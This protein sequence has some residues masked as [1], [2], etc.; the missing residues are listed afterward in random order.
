M[1]LLQGGDAGGKVLVILVRRGQVLLLLPKPAFQS[2]NLLTKLGLINSQ[3]RRL[4]VGIFSVRLRLGFCGFQFVHPVQHNCGEDWGEKTKRPEKGGVLRGLLLSF[5]ELLSHLSEIGEKSLVGGLKGGD[6]LSLL[7]IAGLGEIKILLR[8][9]ELGLKLVKIALK[10]LGGLI[11]RR[12]GR[13]GSRTART[14]QGGG[15]RR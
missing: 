7:L 1:L 4:L 6:S 3:F 15:R 5:G 13:K 12:D 9:R 11:R 2:F 10:L 14:H 8:F